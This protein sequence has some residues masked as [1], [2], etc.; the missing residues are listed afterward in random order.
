VTQPLKRGL[1]G[2]RRAGV[3]Q[4]LADRQAMFER[5]TKDAR[6]AEDRARALEEERD[7]VTAELE[8]TRGELETLRAELEGIG[9]ELQTIRTER[10]D[11]HAEQE[12]MLAEL[13]TTRTERDAVRSEL[14]GSEQRLEAANARAMRS[15]SE[16]SD[17]RERI[18][19]LEDAQ[20][21]QMPTTDVVIAGSTELDLMLRDTERTIH[22]MF[23]DARKGVEQELNDLEGRR[24]AVRADL[25]AL[26]VKR[27]RLSPLARNVREALLEA[28]SR[29]EETSARLQVALAPLTDTVER[30][31][32]RIGD[33]MREAEVG[34]EPSVDITEEELAG[35][36]V[37]NVIDLAAKPRTAGSPW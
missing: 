5:A 26:M 3:Q 19:E 12:R 37:R 2:Y 11:A 10:D 35:G 22:R 9:A 24:D 14:A 34:E 1:F 17:A 13:M 15:A 30:L 25:E 20:G 4:V 21:T 8:A 32:E 31:H 27:D 33:L 23:D 16:L 29:T 36:D 28:R 7:A 18:R 6:E